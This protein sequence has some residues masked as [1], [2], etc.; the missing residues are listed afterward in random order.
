VLFNGGVMK[1]PALRGRV[2]EVLSGWL[3]AEGFE[4]L[5]GSHVLESADL[6]HAV[7]QGAAYYGLARRGRGIRIRSG[8]PRTYYVGIESAMPAVPGMMAP[9]KALCVVPF[10]MEEG[11][12]A[13]LPEREFGLVVGE[14]AEFRFLS[15]TI[16]K[17]DPVGALIDDWGD[18]LEELSPLEVT[19]QMD[20][21]QDV[22]VPVTLE[23]RV[24]EIGTMELWCVGRDRSQR[25]KLELNIRERE[26]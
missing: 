11:T 26:A 24:T 19:L 14:P 5:D 20:A 23:S 6:D 7:A 17:S 2:S 1:A 22:T 4:A 25:W 13:S 18:D 8:A 10:G 12:S 9:L 21:L 16:R 15:S 3:R